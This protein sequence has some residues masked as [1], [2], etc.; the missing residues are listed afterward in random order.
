[1]VKLWLNQ[2]YHK[3]IIYILLK[4]KYY[5]KLENIWII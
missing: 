3:Y 5:K 4:L 1:M 2:W